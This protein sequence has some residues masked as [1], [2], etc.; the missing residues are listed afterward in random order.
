MCIY[1]VSLLLVGAEP[2]IIKLPTKFVKK[3]WEHFLGYLAFPFF[4]LTR[5]V[6]IQKQRI[7]NIHDT[8]ILRPCIALSTSRQWSELSI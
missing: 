2:I 8:T 6:L 3:A 1:R 5:F 7:A 4:L